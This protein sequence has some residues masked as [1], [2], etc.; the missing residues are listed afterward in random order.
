MKNHETPLAIF[1][2]EHG[3]RTQDPELLKLTCDKGNTLEYYQHCQNVKEKQH[4]VPLTF[5][6]NNL[7]FIYKIKPELVNKKAEY[8]FKQFKKS[9]I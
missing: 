2:L 7:E 6:Q 4:L 5:I 9:S 8:I 3:W 1:Q